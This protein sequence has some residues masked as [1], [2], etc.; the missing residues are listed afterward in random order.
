MKAKLLH[1]FRRMPGAMREKEKSDNA[2]N[3]N[4]S[5]DYI[6]PNYL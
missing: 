3:E 2:T 6:N 4:I 5:K 1:G